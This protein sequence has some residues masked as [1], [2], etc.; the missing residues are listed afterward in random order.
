MP[1]VSPLIVHVVAPLVAQLCEVC[2]GALA[3][4]T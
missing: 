4:A 2:A 1:L 3:D